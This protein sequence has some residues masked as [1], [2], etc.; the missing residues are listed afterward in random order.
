MYLGW[1]R[2]GWRR[3]VWNG[4]E[5][6]RSRSQRWRGEAKSAKRGG[7]WGSCL[8]EARRHSSDGSF[9]NQ[10]TS[11]DPWQTCWRGRT[12]MLFSS[13]RKWI[14]WCHICETLQLVDLRHH[15]LPFCLPQEPEWD[16]S[17]A[18]FANAASHIKPKGSSRKSKENKENES[19]REVNER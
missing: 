9:G 19:R 4:R 10:R 5:R 16:V 12:T 17:S 7:E 3:R 2:G 8:T 14:S 18:F 15:C 13:L 11:E 6:V 1:W